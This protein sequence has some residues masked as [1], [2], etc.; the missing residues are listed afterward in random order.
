MKKIKKAEIIWIC[1]VALFYILY[2][3]PGIPKYG[4][5]SGMIKHALFT[6]IPLWISLFLGQGFMNKLYVLR[7][8]DEDVK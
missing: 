2:N 4:D 7:E 3:F 8:E 1:V 5:S 6:I